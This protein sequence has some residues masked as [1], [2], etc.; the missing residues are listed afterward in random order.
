MRSTFETRL[1]TL[2]NKLEAAPLCG[3]ADA[4]FALFH[5]AW[6][7][8]N[9]AHKSPPALLAHWRSQRLCSEHGWQ[10]L[11]TQAA[12]LSFAESPNIRVY[13]HADGGI[14]IQRMAP[15]CGSILCA[16]LGQARMELAAVP[17]FVR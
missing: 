15:A 5:A 2:L 3:N 1:V 14:V 6:L 7:A 11:H 8:T 12:H 9:E 16:K 13:L 17:E 10:D 4:A